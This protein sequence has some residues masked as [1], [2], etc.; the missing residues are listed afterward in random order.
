MPHLEV[1]SAMLLR[2][3]GGTRLDDIVPNKLQIRNEDIVVVEKRWIDVV[4]A[5]KKTAPPS[6]DRTGR[7]ADPAELRTAEQQK[8]RESHLAGSTLI[9]LSPVSI[10]VQVVTRKPVRCGLTAR[11]YW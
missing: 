1:C 6:R 9:V 3:V 8:Q 4:G 5:N 7:L 11:S 2:P 10:A